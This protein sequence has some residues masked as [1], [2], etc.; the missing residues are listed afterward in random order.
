M[1]PR[2]L[3]SRLL[4]TKQCITSRR[5]FEGYHEVYHYF[6]L[7]NAA[8]HRGGNLSTALLHPSLLGANLLHHLHLLWAAAPVPVAPPM[9]PSCLASFMDLMVILLHDAPN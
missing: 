2:D 5:T 4:N 9:T 1:T 3:Y 7:A 8:S 6:S